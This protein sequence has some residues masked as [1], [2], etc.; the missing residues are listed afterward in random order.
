MDNDI[1]DTHEW[2]RLAV[3]RKGDFVHRWG[4]DLLVTKVAHKGSHTTLFYLDTDGTEKSIKDDM[5][6]K[7][8]ARKEE[9]IGN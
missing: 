1:S 4:D 7:Y 3:F 9:A 5:A 8:I 6:K 2:R